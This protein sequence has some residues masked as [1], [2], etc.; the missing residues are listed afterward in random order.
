MCH[1]LHESF[2][3]IRARLVVALLRRLSVLGGYN[4]EA[5]S[6]SRLALLG[7]TWDMVL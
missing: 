3:S 1:D 5:L 7:G 2:F 4:N 6:P